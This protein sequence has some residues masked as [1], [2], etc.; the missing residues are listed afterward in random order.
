MV[1]HNS[2]NEVLFGTRGWMHE[3]W[4]DDYY[5]PDLP[6]DWQLAYY[7]NDASAVLVT[8]SECQ[9]LTLDYWQ[10][11]ADELPEHFRLYFELADASLSLNELRNVLGENFG[12]LLDCGQDVPEADCFIRRDSKIESLDLWTRENDALVCLDVSGAD[13]RMQRA[14]IEQV[15]DDLNGLSK[16]VVILTGDSITPKEL[17]DFRMM[18]EMMGV[19]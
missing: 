16:L 10:D 9:E 19:A 17:K 2:P 5:P 15:L 1:T 6:H 13:L 4:L 7:A 11:V 18:L 8:S 14:L 12:G 3:K